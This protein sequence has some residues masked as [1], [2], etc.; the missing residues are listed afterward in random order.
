MSGGSDLLSE[1]DSPVLV[2]AAQPLQIG[3]ADDERALR[4]LNA[5]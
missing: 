2:R 4:E 1:I 3:V 5:V